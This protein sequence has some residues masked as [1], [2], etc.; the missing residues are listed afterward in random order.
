[1]SLRCYQSNLL[2]NDGGRPTT[3]F[4][5]H[6]CETSRIMFIILYGNFKILVPN[7]WTHFIWQSA[8]PFAFWTHFNCLFKQRHTAHLGGAVHGPGQKGCQPKPHCNR[9]IRR[10]PY[11][12]YIGKRHLTEERGREW[13]TADP[14]QCSTVI[15]WRKFPQQHPMEQS[16][17]IFALLAPIMSIIPV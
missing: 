4:G 7:P 17:R 15:A 8:H 12:I 9:K 10:N 1:M 2:T 14:L 5:N 11:N 3:W 16:Q 6:C 13:H